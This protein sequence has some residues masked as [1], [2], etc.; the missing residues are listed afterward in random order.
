MCFGTAFKHN[1]MAKKAKTK[2]VEG[3]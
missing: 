2:S 1:R 3:Y